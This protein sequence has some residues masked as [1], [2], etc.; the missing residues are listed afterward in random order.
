M[1]LSQNEVLVIPQQSLYSTFQ[2]IASVPGSVCVWFC[3]VPTTKHRAR[4]VG[5]VEMDILALLVFPHLAAS[6]VTN[7]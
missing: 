2:L 1:I 3:G 5:G 7:S 6:Q 4:Q